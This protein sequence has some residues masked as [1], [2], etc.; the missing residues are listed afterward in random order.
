[1]RKA[2][3]RA[4]G[5]APRRLW[6]RL[7]FERNPLRRPV[8]RVQRLVASGLLLVLLAAG[9]PMAAW[10]SGWAYDA[11]LRAEHSERANRQPTVA[12][13]VADGRPGSSGDRY[14]H[15]TVQAS[16]PG[17]DGRTRV[18]PLP[19]WKNAKTGARKTIWIDRRTGEPAVRPRP[20]TRTVTDAAYAGGAAVIVLGLPLLLVYALARRH[21]DRHRDALWEADWAQMDADAGHNRPS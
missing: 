8:D 5:S 13:V 6:R 20:H 12:T 11:G 1:M 15:E 16:W 3:I 14:I 17:P 21:C 2:G 18:G 19:S 4:T 9:P 10:C 7:G